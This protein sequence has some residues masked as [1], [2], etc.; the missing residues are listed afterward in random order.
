MYFYF[1]PSRDSNFA[2]RKF[3]QVDDEIEASDRLNLKS[4]LQLQGKPTSRICNFSTCLAKTRTREVDPSATWLLREQ[5]CHT[6]RELN[7]PSPPFPAKTKLPTLRV[8]PITTVAPLWL[9]R[10][11]M[12]KISAGYTNPGPLLMTAHV[13]S[14]D[15]PS[16]LP[17]TAPP[18]PMSSLVL[19][20][21]FPQK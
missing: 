21:L 3:Y 10:L 18:R 8:T 20:I 13:N 17:K 12:P 19:A 2:Y 7:E 16:R 11:I 14:I 5:R 4:K 6:T 15:W 1:P 9:V